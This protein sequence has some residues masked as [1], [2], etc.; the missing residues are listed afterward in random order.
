MARLGNRAKKFGACVS[1]KTRVCIYTIV[2]SHAPVLQTRLVSEPGHEKRTGA[3]LATPVLDQ[4]WNGKL[5]VRKA[6]DL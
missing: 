4:L 6:F 5:R 3:L 2:S 1:L